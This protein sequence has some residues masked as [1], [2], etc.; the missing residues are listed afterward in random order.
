MPDNKYLKVTIASDS[1]TRS[2]CDGNDL[3]ICSND[4][5]AEAYSDLD[6]EKFGGKNDSEYYDSCTLFLAV[7]LIAIYFTYQLSSPR[8]LNGYSSALIFVVL[9]VVELTVITI[10]PRWFNLNQKLK[11][12]YE[13]TPQWSDRFCSL[14]SSATNL[15]ESSGLYVIGDNGKLEGL[16]KVDAPRFLDIEGSEAIRFTSDAGREIL[17]YPDHILSYESIKGKVVGL[18]TSS[19]SDIKISHTTRLHTAEDA[20]EYPDGHIVAERWEYANKDG[21]KDK[22]RKDNRLINTYEFHSVII[23]WGMLN[24]SIVS[25]NKRHATEY[26]N[27]LADYSK[28]LNKLLIVESN[29]TTTRQDSPPEYPE[30]VVTGAPETPSNLDQSVP[31]PLPNQVIVSP[32]I[33]P[34]VPPP[35]PVCQQ[36]SSQSNGGTGEAG[37]IDASV[38]ANEEGLPLDPPRLTD[39]ERI[40]SHSEMV[41]NTADTSIHTMQQEAKEQLSPI[42]ISDI[43]R[44]LIK[45]AKNF[46]ESVM[47]NESTQVLREDVFSVFYKT[48]MVD[49]FLYQ[50]VAP[51]NDSE[52]SDFRENF[53]AED[54]GDGRLLLS[55][56]KAV[57]SFCSRPGAQVEKFVDQNDE[58][59]F[60][61]ESEDGV[62]LSNQRLNYIKDLSMVKKCH[63]CNGHK[64]VT[65]DDNECRGQHIYTCSRCSGKG[66]VGCDCCEET[67][68]IECDECRGST[69]VKCG[70]FFGSTI[71]GGRNMGCN[72]SGKV[73][74]KSGKNNTRKINC[75]TCRGKGDIKCEKCTR[76][77]VTCSK[78]DGRK[79]VTCAKCD[80][81]KKLTCA[82]CNTNG[83]VVCKTCHGEG[84]LVTLSWVVSKV[85]DSNIRKTITEGDSFEYSESLI[86]DVLQ[87]SR[88]TKVTYDEL[89]EKGSVSEDAI[90]ENVL[91]KVRSMPVHDSHEIFPRLLK[92]ELCYKVIP[93]VKVNCSH[94]LT[95]ETIGIVIIDVKRTPVIEK[96]GDVMAKKNEMGTSVKS[97]FGKL[98]KTKR[99]AEKIDRY[100]QIKLMI[101]IAKADGLID[102]HEKAFLNEHMNSLIDFTTKE[103][104]H[105]LG[106]MS[107]DELPVLSKTDIIF[108]SKSTGLEI[109]SVLEQLAQSDGLYHESERRV[110]E[111]VKAW[112]E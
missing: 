43:K 111:Q 28:S 3:Q 24:C 17:I 49:R 104:I 87:V 80:G 52:V 109:I 10:F 94:I 35:F 38:E 106:L 31:P 71:F 79:K 110:I 55:D 81:E 69:R 40:E 84:N 23:S 13:L 21:S 59:V 7:V 67:G 1:L 65:C 27:A 4:N 44:A 93:V 68:K 96:L 58:L 50:V 47:I 85:E 72:G 37:T 63:T 103:K 100:N 57:S 29:Q 99:Y 101:Y 70:S 108:S 112:M 14:T 91:A 74:V 18:E 60:L 42:S 6:F 25:S 66:E 22:R 102:D 53:F 105:L 48:T 36:K 26:L 5:I 90:A 107:V 12:R 62:C 11:L 75:P 61:L 41:E 73:T 19:V 89:S 86:K 46:A 16:K 30:L 45:S 78:C 2:I 8:Y 97:L 32:N 54:M 39:D 92:D 51:I 9:V 33:D 20:K 15:A 83:K 34:S 56:N 98:L 76:G 64:E 95:K 88:G 77:K 82:L